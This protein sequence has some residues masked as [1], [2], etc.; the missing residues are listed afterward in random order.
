MCRKVTCKGDKI[1]GEVY[2]LLWLLLGY[3]IQYP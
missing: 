2:D 1:S 3:A